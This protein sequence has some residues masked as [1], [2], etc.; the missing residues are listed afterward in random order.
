MSVDERSGEAAAIEARIK[1][2]KNAKSR[3][4]AVFTRF[5]NQ[6]TVLLSLDSDKEVISSQSEKLGEATGKGNG[7]YEGFVRGVHGKKGFGK[8]RHG[9]C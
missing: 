4:K 9:Q 7:C 1:T 2:L 3:A 5:K 8:C 6:L